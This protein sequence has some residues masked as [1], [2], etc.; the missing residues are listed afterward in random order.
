MEIYTRGVGNERKLGWEAGLIEVLLGIAKAKTLNINDVVIAFIIYYQRF[1]KGL[2]VEE[3]ADSGNDV[4]YF[5][6][7][8]TTGG[9]IFSCCDGSPSL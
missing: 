3:K 6:L 7:Y 1:V 9:Y 8:N 4:L 5:F 2:F